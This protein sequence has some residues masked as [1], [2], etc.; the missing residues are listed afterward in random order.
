MG[1][2]GEYGLV[3][4][5]GS[6]R[7]IGLIAWLAGLC[8]ACSAEPSAEP[9]IKPIKRAAEHPSNPALRMISDRHGACLAGLEH[10]LIRTIEM[11]PDYDF[12][13][14]E[15]SGVQVKFF[16]GNHPAFDSIR[17]EA[18]PITDEYRYIAREHSD[19]EDK[20]LYASRAKAGG[21]TDVVMFSAPSLDAI[22][23]SFKVGS[24]VRCQVRA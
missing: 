10:A 17:Y 6:I 12:G 19:G 3:V 4:R 23:S 2:D 5:R 1:V 21:N 11:G 16:V 24:V 13:R 22:A 20:I 14:M 15:L 18:I 9:A 8:V 7:A